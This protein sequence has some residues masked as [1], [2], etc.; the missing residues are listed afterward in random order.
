MQRIV[1]ALVRFRNPISYLVLLGLSIM[2]LNGR[3]SFHQN[4]LEKYSLYFSQSIY[5]FSHRIE[6]YFNLKIYHLIK[7]E[8]Q[9]NPLPNAAKH[10]ISPF[11][12]FPLSK[13]SF[14]AIGIEAAV[15]FPYF[16]MLLNT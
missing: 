7:A 2:F 15:V 5:S 3:S 12:N 4:H 8:A 1:E 16:I 9:V 6:N 11:F 10:K 14:N 13:A